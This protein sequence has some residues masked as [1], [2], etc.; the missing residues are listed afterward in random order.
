MIRG[1]GPRRARIAMVT[2]AA[3]GALLVGSLGCRK[4]TPPATAAPPTPAPLPGPTQGP[5]EPAPTAPAADGPAASPDDEDP[6]TLA[7]A[8]AKARPLM[9]GDAAGTTAGT[10]VLIGWSNRHLRWQDVAVDHDE[11]S[12]ALL[13]KDPDA[14]KGKRI[15][16]SGKIAAMNP[17]RT[18]SA[19]YWNGLLAAPRDRAFA[20]SA[21]GTAGTLAA[22]SDA[23]V[24]GVVTGHGNVTTPAGRPAPAIVLV[25]MFDLPENHAR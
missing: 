18:D 25:G 3:L 13:K 9:T 19:L 23:R 1:A 2:A 4:G 12:A 22:G 16:V 6:P 10:L 17:V 8:I 15:C 21:V 20:F 7:T 24:C 14:Q 5:G 11:T